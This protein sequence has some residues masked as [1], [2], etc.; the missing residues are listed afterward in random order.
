MVKA[1]I[2]QFSP[3][4]D[5]I[6]QQNCFNLSLKLKILEAI[7]YFSWFC[8]ASIAASLYSVFQVHMF[9][10]PLSRRCHKYGE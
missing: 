5:Y 6:D 8:S 4:N 9:L 7:K 10:Q 1:I 2:I 3:V